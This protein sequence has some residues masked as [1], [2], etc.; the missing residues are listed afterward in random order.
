[1][2]QIIK[3]INGKY[4]YLKSIKENINFRWTNIP[5]NGITFDANHS[6]DELHALRIKFNADFVIVKQPD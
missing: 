3:K 4:V 2:F 5:D 6:P 1:M